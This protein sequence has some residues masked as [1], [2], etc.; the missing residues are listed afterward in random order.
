MTALAPA[1]AQPRLRW[2]AALMVPAFAVGIG[3]VSGDRPLIVLLAAMGVLVALACLVR[4]DAA[5][6]LVLAGLYG[7][8]TAVAV[9]DFGLPYFV[10]TLFPALLLLPLGYHLV[11]KRRPVAVSPALPFLVVYLLAMLLGG[12]A[13]RD[14]ATAFDQVV[15]FVST[16]LVMFVILTNVLRTESVLRQ[17]TWVVVLVG[18]GMAAIVVHQFATSSFGSEYFGFAQVNFPGRGGSILDVGAG[19]V[20]LSGPIGEV[21]RFGQVLA[22][23]VPMGAML[24]ASARSLPLRALAAGSMVITLAG[25]ATTGSRGA[26]IAVIAVGIALLALGHLRLRHLALVALL[27]AGLLNAF[28]T[29]GERLAGLQA[30]GAL[31]GETAGPAE[32][33]VGNLRSRATE[34]VAALI[35]FAD[36]PLVG[37]GP[38]LFPFYYQQYARE[39]SSS[40]LDTRVDAGDRQAHNLFADVLAETGIV[41]FVGF[42]G[43]LLVTASSLWRVR[44][45]WRSER[46][47]LSLLA[48][49]YLLGLL[50]YAASGMFLH[51]SYERFFWILLSLAAAVAIVGLRATGPDQEPATPRMSPTRLRG[52]RR[53]DPGAAGGTPP[54]PV[55]GERDGAPGAE[56]YVDDGSA[57]AR[58]T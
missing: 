48:T 30:L 34:S 53:P 56:G 45:R 23:L 10:A 36:H 57:G 38:G 27:V 1:P 39:V 43:A 22:V 42:M 11:V 29:Y 4:P 16:G 46:R 7:N 21:N 20:R 19:V 2:A 52:R 18:A 44:R 9:R 32:G 41:G 47:D 17:A 35:A 58:S 14:P 37:V 40:A 15:E 5:T 51:L 49:G 54:G 31:S 25:I 28:P 55:A 3:L 50:A 33:D 24:A 13:S 26:A 12:A 6:L 8:A